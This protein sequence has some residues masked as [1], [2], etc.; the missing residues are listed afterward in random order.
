[1]EPDFIIAENGLG[2]PK[3]DLKK[4]ID[5]KESNHV[6]FVGL[7]KDGIPAS[8]VRFSLLYND[9]AS[10]LLA[11]GSCTGFPSF[12]H[13]MRLRTNDAKYN[14]EQGFYAAMNMMDKQVEFNYFH[15][16][17]LKIGDKYLYYVGE[18]Q[19]AF[20]EII[21]KGD[22]ATGKFVVFYVYGNEIVGFCTYGY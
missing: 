22:P 5:V 18:P 7:D 6:N 8:N 17:Q 3:V 12:L 16:Y 19:N 20:T 15:M 11:A 4:I 21:T 13:K 14:I 1:M 10:P 9:I 2:Q